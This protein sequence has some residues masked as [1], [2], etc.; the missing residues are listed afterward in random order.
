MYGNNTK[1]YGWYMW[2][3]MNRQ[4]ELCEVITAMIKDKIEEILPQ[5]MDEYMKQF[6]VNI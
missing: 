6:S 5:L 2:F 4:E 3:L 1:N